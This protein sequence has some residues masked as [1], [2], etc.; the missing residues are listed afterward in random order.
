VIFL[1]PEAEHCYFWL[2]RRAIAFAQQNRVTERQFLED[3]AR[4]FQESMRI[5][6]ANCEDKPRPKRF[7]RWDFKSA[8]FPL[9]DRFL[10]AKSGSLICS[11]SNRPI[12]AFWLAFLG[13]LPILRTSLHRIPKCV[14][15]PDR[16]IVCLD[17]A[18]FY[19]NANSR[20]AY[21]RCFL[22]TSEESKDLPF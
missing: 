12:N 10:W 15:L 3:A 17:P 4:I 14:W 7:R 5:E 9:P 21:P 22:I 8:S 1:T 6:N 20:L 16:R 19:P 13:C 2:L 11:G 18:S